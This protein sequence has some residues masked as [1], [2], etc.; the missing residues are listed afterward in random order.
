[1]L[2]ITKKDKKGLKFLSKLQKE[3]EQR[4]PKIVLLWEIGLAG[5]FIGI[6]VF[7]FVL[8]HNGAFNTYTLLIYFWISMFFTIL[9]LTLIYILVLTKLSGR[10]LMKKENNYKIKQTSPEF[11][12]KEGIFS[13]K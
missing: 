2:F 13:K 9:A 5:T 3:A 12:K 11:L 10:I 4:K 8:T 1:M 7:S 6:L